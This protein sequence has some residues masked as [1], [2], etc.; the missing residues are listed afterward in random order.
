MRFLKDSSTPRRLNVLQVW[1]FQRAKK[2]KL[3]A[4]VVPHN[5]LSSLPSSPISMEEKICSA[6]KLIKLRQQSFSRSLD[7]IHDQASSILTLQRKNI[8]TH[9]DSTFISIEDSAKDLHAKERRLEEREKEIDSKEK[10]F[11][12]RCEEFIKLRD[13]E[14]KEI[15]ERRRELEVER[16]KLVEKI[17]LKEEKLEERR[18]ENEVERKKLVEGIES[19]EKK[20]EE[21]QK[22]IEVERKKLDEEVELK[23]KQIKEGHMEISW[24]KLKVEEQLKEC[25]LKERRI[26][27]RALEIELERKRNVECLEELKLKQKEVELEGMK[28]KKFIEESELKEKRFD[29]RCKEVESERKKLAEKLELKEKQLV[30]QQK[31]VEFENTK[32]KKFFK[33]LELKEKQVEERRLVVELGNKKFVDGVQSKEKQLEERCKVVEL[34]KKKFEEQSREIELKEKHPEEQLK[35]VVLANKRFFKHDKELELKEKQ[36]L[37]GFKELEMGILVKLKEEESKEWRRELGLKEIN[38]GQKVRERYDEFELK[39]KKFEEEFREVALREAR[40]EKRFREVALRE[41]RVEKR[42]REVEEKERRAGEL[43]KKVKVKEDKFREWRKGVELK[44]K[45]L[46]LKGWEVEERLKEVG[47]KDTKVKERLKEVKLMEKNVGKRSEEVELNGSKLEEGFREL[48]LKRREVEEIIIGVELKE[49]EL[50]ERCRG[51]DLK[52]KQIEE[53]QLREKKPEER[54]REVELENKKCL[55][56]IKEFES[57]EKQPVDASNARV[58]S[59]TADCSLDANLHFS[60]KMDGKALQIFLNKGCKHDEKMKNEVSIALRLSSDPAKLVLDAMEG[61]YPPHLREGDVEFKEVVVKRSCNLLLEQVMKISP[62]IK[63][64][65]RKEATKLAFL[66]MTKMTVDNQ[67]CL[68]VLGFFNLLAAYGLASAFDSDELISRL[69][70]IARNRQTP[71]FLR[72]LELGDKIPGFIQNLILKKQPMEAIRFSFA[73]QMFNQ[74]PPETMLRDYLTCSKI[75]ARKIRWSSNSIEGMVESLNRRVSDLV[76]VLKCV[77]DYKLESIFSPITLKQQIKDVERQL[78]IRKTKLP[79]LDSKSPQPNLREKNRLAPK[80]AT[81]ALVLPSNSVSATKPAL[82]STM[83]ASTATSTTPIGVTS[84][85]TIA[86]ATTSPIAVASCSTAASITA[87]TTRSRVAP[88]SSTSASPSA[89]VPMT[90]SPYQGG[91]K[92]CQARYRGSDK[93]PQEQHLGGNKRPRIAKS[94]EAPLRAPSLQSTGNARTCPSLIGEKKTCNCD[95]Y[96][97]P[98]PQMSSLATPVSGARVSSPTSMEEKICSEVKLTKLRQQSFSRSFNEIH[99][100]ASSFLLLAL[101]WRELET[102]FDSTFTSIEDCARELQTKERQ[103]EGREK[104]ADSKEKEFVERCEEFIKLRDAE[105]KEIEERRRELEVERKKL[106]EGIMLKEKKIEERRGELE[107]ERKKLVEGIMLKEKKIEERRKE[108]EVERK[109]LVEGIMLKEKR[110][111]ERRKEIEVERKNLVEGIM[112]KEKRFEERRKEIEVERKNLVEGIMLKEKRF[113]ERR[114]EIEVERKNLVEGIES[115]EKKIE[116]RQKEIEVERKKLDEEV[117]LKEKKIEERRK[118]IEVERRKQ[119]NEGYMEVARVKLK[120]GEQLKECELME[121][122]LEDRALEIE[123]ERKRNVECIEEL[124]LKQREVEL[125]GM[126]YKKFIEEFELKEKRFDERWKEVELERKKLLEK[127]EFKEK[128]LVEQQKEVELENFKIKKFFEELELKEK[129]VEERRLVVESGNKKLFEE[130]ESKEKQLEER[131]KIV[132]LENKKFEERFKEIELKEKHLEEQLEEVE[133]GNKMVSEQAEGLQ[134]KE[135]QLLQRFKDLEI[136]IKNFMDKTRELEL[137]KRQLEEQCKQLDQKRKRFV[138]AGSTRVKFETPDDFVVKN[139]T[140]ADLRLLLTMDGK[141]LQIFLNK[142]RKYDEKTKNEVLT[143]LGLSS[144]PAELVLGALEGFYP[145]PIS[146]SDV[147]YNGI[148]VK[149]SCNLLL[150]QLMALSPPIK[151]HVREAARELAF[152]W[153]TKM[154]KDRYLEVLGFFRLL[155]CYGLASVFD[156]CEL[157]NDLVTVAQQRQ[158]PELLRVLGLVDEASRFIQILINKKQY[159]DAIN[160]IYAFEL[161]KEFHPVLLLKDHLHDSKIAAKKSRR[162]E[163]S[164]EALI[165]SKEK[166]VADLRAVIKCVEDHKLESELSLKLLKGQIANLEMEI[167]KKKA[168][169][170]AVGY[171]SAS[172]STSILNTSPIPFPTSSVRFVPP[173]QTIVLPSAT[174]SESLAQQHRGNEHPQPQHRGGYKRPRMAFSSEVPLQASSSANPNVVHLQPP[175]Q[176]PDH[177]FM[178]QV[179]I[180]CGASDI[181]T[182]ENSIVWIGDDDIFKNSQSEV[183]QSSNTVSHVMSTLRVFTSLKKNCYPITVDKGSLVLVRA[184]FFYGNYDKKSSPPSFHLLFDGNYWA[185]VNTTLDQLVYCEVMYFVKSDTTSICLAQTHPNQFPFISALEVRILDSKMY[186]NVDQNHALFLRSRVAYGAN[187]TVR[188]PDDAYDR[189]W[190]PARIGSGLVSVASDATLI[191]VANAPDNPPQKV[192]QNAITTSSSSGSITL[193]RG[194]PDQDVSVYMNLYFSEVTALDTTQK[195]SFNFYIDN[196]KESEP[197]IPPYGEALEMNG[198]FT[199]SANT[200]ISLVSTTNS[201]LPPLINA[202]EMFFV[203]DRLTDG[204]DSKDVKGLGELQISFSVLQEIWS[205]DPCL[206][207]P[208]TWDRISCSNDVIPRVTA[209]DLS[210]LDLSGPLPDFSS[211]DALV[212]I[213]LHNNSITGP[214]PDFLG[215]LANLEDLNLADNS[216]SGPIP[217]SISSNKKLKLVASGNPNLC[218]SGKSCQPT[219]TDGTIIK[220]TP[221][222]RRKKSNKLPVILGSTIPISIIFWAIVGFLVHHRRKTTAIAA[223]IGGQT[224]GANKPSG[225]NTMMGEVDEAV[226]NEITVNIQDQT[227]SENG[228]QSFPQQ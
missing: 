68:D 156:A 83:V 44:E 100:Q 55:E 205:G 218:V 24:L 159:I 224:G 90:E 152:D 101:Q 76:A 148:V 129:Q 119:L 184:S 80:T 11:E 65:V 187:S 113:E 16:K 197:I 27:D 188:F 114:K 123:L 10:E 144:D 180:D 97:P 29:E 73:F 50:E 226:I 115:K 189:I 173:S 176:Q 42:F 198:N 22:E 89:S 74:F 167:T 191:D 93:P 130:V 37:E 204:T 138:D 28:Y 66:W 98:N 131:C 150:E 63:P 62:P 4:S 166:R 60:V 190:V 181:Y 108:I 32:N 14:E 3:F 104:E 126:K 128:Q 210:S 35:E 12:E 58:K 41:E 20:I 23:E 220:S 54:L 151:P 121:R 48:E 174:I 81:S 79:D 71:E 201:T 199:A 45:E 2:T 183:V 157:F 36:L 110:F 46:E 228:V 75:A 40:A 185:N 179:S 178:N 227:T 21:R 99:E 162:R 9:F 106:V 172:T 182:D 133:L 84:P 160:F 154:K 217:S 19:R 34:E 107:V 158:T 139:A 161:V 78:S 70:I 168:M 67:H 193:Y 56:R 208:Y 49:K 5:L 96:P 52:G 102:H 120:V 211:M 177:F 30:E 136:E 137:K 125:E 186:G 111:E 31:E 221:S 153:R 196:I 59:E 103:L 43:F 222:G 38:F 85:S 155:A 82:N 203:S 127:L 142:C 147:A 122:Q 112:L 216:F 17:K 223:I 202:M 124:K 209:L 8:E 140:D 170:L 212:T 169:L 175:H 134:L 1:L 171:T 51:V 13:A 33:V 15:E 77:E 95:G 109:N 26:E 7:E 194:F 192:L 146:N 91:N 117:E 69:V 214:I 116:E 200:S 39:E 72:V 92:R 87:S 149:K 145:P 118:E 18:K 25:E 53:V 206:P 47:L 105:E 132:E 141:A 195:R 219:S 64:H 86:A 94:S 165:I 213:D 88:L 225:A 207:S 57:K 6:L 61:F 215:A 143:A 163:K 135:K 164:V